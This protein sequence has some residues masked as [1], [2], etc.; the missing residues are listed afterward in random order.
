MAG[1]EAK[2]PPGPTM[3][4][5]PSLRDQN[6][7]SSSI[8]MKRGVPGVILGKGF[9]FPSPFHISPKTHVMFVNFSPNPHP[10]TTCN[11]ETQPCQIFFHKLHLLFLFPLTFMQGL[12]P[13][14]LFRSS[15]S[16][17]T[18]VSSP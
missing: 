18:T 13:I 9:G 7:Q 1:A 16:A 12:K 14:S 6:Q 8:R 5:A 11:A 4:R 3:L 2:S 17:L 15:S 10:S